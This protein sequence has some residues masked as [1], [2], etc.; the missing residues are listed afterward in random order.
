MTSDIKTRSRDDWADLFEALDT[1]SGA[2]CTSPPAECTC[3]IVWP[4]KNRLRSRK[5]VRRS[6]LRRTYK[7]FNPT[8]GRMVQCESDLERDAYRL[9]EACPWIELI[10]E[11]PATI[12]WTIADTPHR[13]FPDLLVAIGRRPAFVECK[14]SVAAASQAV[15]ER[16]AV[17]RPALARL[18]YGYA[19]V[20][21]AVIRLQPRLDHV[22]RLLRYGRHPVDAVAR[23][24]IRRWVSDQSMP[25]TW[26]EILSTPDGIVLRAQIC[27]LV[28]EGQLWLPLHAAWHDTT[29]LYPI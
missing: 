27:R 1:R 24:R 2:D 18:G 13:H 4:E 15:Q 28:L 3:H 12:H 9:I 25:H 5:V 17:L 8:L 29:P 16:T 26:G 20:T 6:N 10:S 21:E 22:R 14:D 23:E 19:L 11:Q 7:I